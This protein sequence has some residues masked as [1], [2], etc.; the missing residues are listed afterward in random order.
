MNSEFFSCALL[1]LKENSVWDLGIFLSE[2]SLRCSASP[3][4]GELAFYSRKSCYASVVFAGT[5]ALC[6][7]GNCQAQ[8]LARIS[9]Q[10]Y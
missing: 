8:S 7:V 3:P 6:L 5:E 10:F 1:S 4:L 9:R 2:V